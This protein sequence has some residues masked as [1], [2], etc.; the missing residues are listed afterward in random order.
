MRE[1]TGHV[2]VLIT[3]RD[4]RKQG[5]SIMLSSFPSLCTTVPLHF[6]SP[7]PILHHP[8]ISCLPVYH[9]SFLSTTDRPSQSLLHCSSP[10][11]IEAVSV[12]ARSQQP[13]LGQKRL[14]VPSLA[15]PGQKLRQKIC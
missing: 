6:A 15:L 11:G 9:R 14:Q 7:V 12:V 4:Q 2:H 5:R 10:S 8:A 13:V 3:T 1:E